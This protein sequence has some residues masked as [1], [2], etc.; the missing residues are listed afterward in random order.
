MKL[1]VSSNMD[2]IY[3]SVKYQISNYNGVIVAICLI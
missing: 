3:M 2:H 1:C